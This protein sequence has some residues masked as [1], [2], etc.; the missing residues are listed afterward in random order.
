MR[1]DRWERNIGNLNQD[2]LNELR[3][4]RALISNS[5]RGNRVQLA[6]AI[7]EAYKYPFT[8]EIMHADIQE[9]CVLPTLPSIFSRYESSVQHLKQYTLSLMQWGRNDAVLCRYFPVSLDGEALAWF[10]GLPERSISSFKDLQKIFLTTY[11]TNN[12]LRPGIETLFNLRRIPT[13]SLRGLVTRW[14]TVCSEL[15]GRVDE[16]NF[17]L[18]FV[19][20]LIPTDLLYTQIFIIRNSLTMNE[21]REYQEE[22]I[23]LEKKQRQVSEVAPMPAKEGN[24]S[25]LPRTVHVVENDSKHEKG[26]PSTPVPVKLVVVSG[27]DQEWIDQQKYEE[28]RR[29]NYEPRSYNAGYQQRNNQGPR[30]GE[31]RPKPPDFEDLK[32]PRI[33]TTVE[34]IWE[35]IVLTE[36]IPPLPNL[37]RNPPLGTRS[38]KLSIYHRFHGHHTRDC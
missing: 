6:E 15:A 34:K 4:M 8:Y 17:I 18:A 28:S 12:M 26:E 37:G 5:R 20:A 35:A 3:D 27:G 23:A 14:R 16:K 13:E 10:D 22:Y 36:E 21:L 25:L 31:R 2:V 1:G 11:I 7:E 33:N 30:F 24:S 29:R 38:H 9:K 32:L 19:N